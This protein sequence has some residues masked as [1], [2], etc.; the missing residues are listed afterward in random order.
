VQSVTRKNELPPTEP[1][2]QS[3][4]SAK[5]AKTSVLLVTGDDGLWPQIGV[6]LGKELILK[7]LDSIN[8]LLTATPSGQPA[9]I[10]W[11]ARNQADAAT[12][13]SRLQ[14][15]SPR[16][17]VV[18]L[19]DASNAQ[20][21]ASPIATRQVIARVGVPIPADQLAA[22]LESALEEVNARVALLGDASD[23]GEAAPVAA[24]SPRSIP[25]IPASLVG[26]ALIAGAGAFF[27]LR[28]SD[29]PVQPAPLA[30]LP[31]APLPSGR[32]AVA[33]D[34]KVDL[35]IEKAHQAM[36]DR[37]YIDPAEGSALKLYRDAL[38]VDPNNG[39]AH[40]GLLRLAE[41][42]ITRV[43]SAL[44]E[45][46]FD[47][48]LQALET[49][50][51]INPGDSRLAALDERTASLRAEIGP[52]QILAAINAQNFDRAAQL[53]DEASRTKSL[54]GA[55]LAQLHDEL[56]RRHE[57]F[58]IANFTKL[59]DTRL[60]QDKLIEPRNDSAVYYLGQARQAGASAA[61]LQGQTQEI[62]KRLTQTM[63]AAIEQRRFADADRLLGELHGYGVPAATVA[64][65]QHDLAAAR[66]QQVAAAPEQPQYLDLAQARLAQGKVTEPDSDSALYYVNQLRTADPKNSALPR[67]SAAVQAPILEQARAA[68]DAAQPAKAE[69]LLQLA[70]GLGASA[71]L[72]ALN[73]RLQNAKLAAA[74]PAEVAE[75]TLTRVRGMEIDYPPEAVRMNIEGWV[76]LSYTVTAQGTIANINVVNSNPV[77]VFDNAAIK[78]LSHMRYK[79]MMQGG[80]PVA[81][82]TKVRVAFH[83]E[84]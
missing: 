1:E 71:D 73:D 42:L 58:D 27:F 22:A 61:A 21:W 53:I 67:L 59:I 33:A 68:L 45:R 29:T 70:G 17:A 76:E 55:K 3:V 79:P 64:S 74:G 12:V 35:L 84:K 60:Q 13:L 80:K 47:L 39:E 83:L 72:N 16:F 57:E 30:V 65:L 37:H 44:D 20:S 24:P 66:P 25:W 31:H 14:M 34:D 2:R 54:N 81:I 15:H 23:A 26:A 38:L 77:R 36:R 43:Q 40:Q 9:I 18:A 41:I 8:E 46:K 10:L 82:S 63:H 32:P 51:S 7:Q 50:R 28:H 49:A 52:A 62:Y 11:D 75:A 19:D 78:A 48:A 4:P 5:R 6:H 56:R 69:A